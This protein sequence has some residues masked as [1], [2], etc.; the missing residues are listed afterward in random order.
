MSFDPE[1]PYTI[2][3][4]NVQ[5]GLPVNLQVLQFNAVTN[6]WEFVILAT[7][8]GPLGDIAY[9]Q[10]KEFAGDLLTDEGTRNAVGTLA[11][12]TAP[13]EKDLY[14]AKAKISAR[15]GSGATKIELQANGVTIATWEG[16]VTSTVNP[17]YEF[18]LSGVKVT[19]G[20][21]L[22]LEVTEI[23][24]ASTNISGEIT[25]VQVDTGV[26]PS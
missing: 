25:C 21:V 22:R 20:Q 3:S 10:G 4:K 5:G 24:S 8:G 7:G 6:Q 18:I 1:N 15:A 2:G 26:D 23:G 9:L 16:T 12:V 19:T 17:F 11:A 13:T 14:L